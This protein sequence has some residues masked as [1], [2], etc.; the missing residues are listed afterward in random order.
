[1]RPVNVAS[2]K[3]Y[4][5]VNVVALWA[6][7]EESGYSSGAWGTY[8]QWSEAGAQ[9]R[10]G[11]KA[12]FVVFYKELEFTAESETGDADTITR[13]FA[14]ATPVFAAEQVD[15]YQPPVIDA[16]LATI[17]TPIEQAEAFVAATGASIHHGGGRAFYR[18]A[19]DS[20]QLPPREAF[21]G[22]PTSSP[23]E[24]YYSTLLHELTHWTSQPSR[25][26]R[27]LGNVS[28]VTPTRSRSWS[29][30]SAP[31]FSVP[32]SASPMSR[33][34]ITR[35]ISRRGF[36]SSR[37]TRRRFSP[38]HRKH[39]KPQRFSQRFTRRERS[40]CPIGSHICQSP[41]RCARRA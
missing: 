11:E 38:P 31:L 22:S 14:R 19:T 26:D 21:I 17:M 28:A 27:E 30:N 29:P 35:N 10:K 13:L 9:V 15:G 25:C 18:P 2:K 7:A 33:A 23:P 41:Q 4:R 34:R 3:P 1:M 39:P 6:Y 24:A 16:P 36:P 37:P 8:R 40:P 5:G 32:I 12:A 20:I